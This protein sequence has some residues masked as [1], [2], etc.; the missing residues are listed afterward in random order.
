MADPEGVQGA[1]EQIISFLRGYSRKMRDHLQIDPLPN[2]SESP[3]LESW[4][5]LGTKRLMSIFQALQENQLK[6]RVLTAHEGS[7]RR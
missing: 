5:R 4:I 3:L 7:S 6:A 1:S 2:L